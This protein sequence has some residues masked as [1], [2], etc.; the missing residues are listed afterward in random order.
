MSEDE[1]WNA[2]AQQKE[3]FFYGETDDTPWDF[4]D[5]PIYPICLETEEHHTQLRIVCWK[6]IAD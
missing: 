2:V 3:L 6:M 1:D 5:H 4:K